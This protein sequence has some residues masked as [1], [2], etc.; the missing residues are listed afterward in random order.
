MRYCYIAK[1]NFY[2][3]YLH[4]IVRTSEH[5]FLTRRFKYQFH[6]CLFCFPVL[7]DTQLLYCP[8]IL[9]INRI[10]QSICN[11]TQHKCVLIVAV[12]DH[13]QN[14]YNQRNK[15]GLHRSS[16][17]RFIKMRKIMSKH[18]SCNLIKCFANILIEI[19]KRN[20]TS[21]IYLYLSRTVTGFFFSSKF[22]E[23]CKRRCISVYRCLYLPCNHCRL[24]GHIC[25]F[26]ILT[27]L[28]YRSL[29]FLR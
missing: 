20:S 11:L 9:S 29:T 13:N 23:D 10:A 21:V 7:C 22:V 24:Y 8:H 19:L 1:R 25:F 12:T 17:A 16:S 5:Y 27:K 26:N 4:W 15:R 14:N 2:G 28:F 6:W 3:L 18:M